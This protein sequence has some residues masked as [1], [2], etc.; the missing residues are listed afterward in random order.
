MDIVFH[1]GDLMTNKPAAFLEPQRDTYSWIW[2]WD[3][4]EWLFERRIADSDIPQA[5]EGYTLLQKH[6]QGA[7]YR[8]N[9]SEEHL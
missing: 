8:K 6:E 5:T 7:F 9:A 1:D 2:T 4:C 3:E